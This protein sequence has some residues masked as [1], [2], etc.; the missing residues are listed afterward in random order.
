MGKITELRLRDVRCF[1]GEQ[2]ARLG[3]ITLLVGENSAGKSTFMGCYRV[4]AKLANLHDLGD[5]NHFD[6]APFRMGSFGTVVR[7]GK[8]DFTIGGTFKNHCHTNAAFTF[9]AENGD[10]PIER[11]VRFGFNDRQGE[12][13]EIRIIRKSSERDALTFEGPNF[14]FDLDRREISYIPILTW[15]SRYVRYGHLPFRGE[16]ADLRARNDV[17]R[18]HEIEFAKFIGFFRSS[19]PF[20]DPPPFIVN[21]LD[22]QSPT[23]ERVY[24][25]L[26]PYLENLESG[27]R[28]EFARFGSKMKLWN[29]ITTEIAPDSRGSKVMV[30]I[31]SG[32]R[33]LVD[34]GYGVHSLLP[35]ISAMAEPESVL[36]LQQ[37]EIHVHPE[38]Q[39]HMAQLMAENS[40]NF[41]IETHSDHFI[42]RLRICVMD[43]NLRPEDLSIVYFERHAHGTKCRIHSISVDSEANLLDVPKNYRTFFLKETERLL[44]LKR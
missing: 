12:K 41:I 6:D 24:S 19:F 15:L 32:L 27:L 43:G 30:E 31:A 18:K 1:D 17:S 10:K 38:A 2:S 25:A 37:P 20:P 36:L 23:R 4:F 40:Q 26:P 44:G 22:P 13:H 29:D 33:N 7:S 21:A 8:S 34:V 35:L 14:R 5:E 39:A 11:E 3:R 16:P 42:D 28:S 9:V